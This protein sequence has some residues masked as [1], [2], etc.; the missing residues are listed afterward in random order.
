MKPT[1][2]NPRILTLLVRS[3]SNQC[4]TSLM[5]RKISEFPPNKVHTPMRKPLWSQVKVQKKSKKPKF[6]AMRKP[7]KKCLQCHKSL[8]S[9][10]KRLSLT[11]TPP[12]LQISTT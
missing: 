2:M 8:T 4:A 11:F 1:F 5:K 7:K 10:S 12:L 6:K 9:T 3:H